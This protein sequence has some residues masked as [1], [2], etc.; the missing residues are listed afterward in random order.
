MLHNAHVLDYEDLMLFW[1]TDDIN[2]AM[3]LDVGYWNYWKQEV[4][5]HK[6]IKVNPYLTFVNRSIT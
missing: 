4:L 5:I 6:E 1:N 3:E 2:K